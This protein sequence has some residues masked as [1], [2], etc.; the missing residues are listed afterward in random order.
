MNDE[1]SSELKWT[2]ERRIVL[3]SEDSETLLPIRKADW[4]RVKRRLSEIPRTTS[5]LS[6]AY[7]IFFGISGTA[8]FSTIPLFSL[9]DVPPWVIPVLRPIWKASIA[10]YKR[11][12]I[13]LK[14]QSAQ[15]R[16]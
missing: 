2:Q 10:H 5:W 8:A 16:G 15:K 13:Q 11:E 14:R 3:P 9:H 6:R 1:V 7:S 4:E 12:E